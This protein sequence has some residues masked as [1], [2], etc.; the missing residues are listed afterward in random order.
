MLGVRTSGQEAACP[1]TDG[2]SSV[3]YTLLTQCQCEQLRRDV[4]E[5]G[6]SSH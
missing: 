4:R 2:S 5:A 6:I 3:S 1:D